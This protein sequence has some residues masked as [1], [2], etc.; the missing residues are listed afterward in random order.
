MNHNRFFFD[1]FDCI[2][3]FKRLKESYKAMA[4]WNDKWKAKD[5]MLF[6]ALTNRIH[7]TVKKS[8]NGQKKLQKKT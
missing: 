8:E 1:D 3:D 2:A 7:F 5:R 6:N 4:I